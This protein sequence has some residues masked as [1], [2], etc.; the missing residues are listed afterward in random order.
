MSHEQPGS[1]WNCACTQ[2]NTLKY[3]AGGWGKS[4]RRDE[5]LLTSY[6]DK[7]SANSG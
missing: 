3:T 5:D 6:F 1:N 2:N 4:A 7:L